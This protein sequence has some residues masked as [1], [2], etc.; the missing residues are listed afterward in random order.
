MVLEHVQSYC[1]SLWSQRKMGPII[2]PA[3]IAHTHTNPSTLCTALHG[4]MRDMQI[5]TSYSNGSCVY[6][7]ETNFTTEQNECCVVLPHAC[8]QQN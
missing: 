8:L 6:W 5:I 2:L 7:A 1:V 3:L 4:L